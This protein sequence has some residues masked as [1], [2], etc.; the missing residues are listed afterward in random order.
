MQA[1]VKELGICVMEVMAGAALRCGGEGRQLGEVSCVS[2]SCAAGE[3]GR[4]SS[5][6]P[7]K[8]LLQDR[9][10]KIGKLWIRRCGSLHHQ[11][12]VQESVPCRCSF[13]V[14]G[15]IWFQE[16]QGVAGKIWFQEEQGVAA[17]LQQRKE[18]S[19]REQLLELIWV[20]CDEQREQSLLLG[21]GEKVMDLRERGTGHGDWGGNG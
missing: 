6:L 19:R 16:E 10:K 14:A 13:G 18:E 12:K 20:G 17:V 7:F 1:V 3:K 11:V 4:C 2:C 8:L 15:K 21:N 5:I 9:E